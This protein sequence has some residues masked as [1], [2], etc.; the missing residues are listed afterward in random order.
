[1]GEQVDKDN[2][3][4]DDIGD[5]RWVWPWLDLENGCVLGAQ[6]LDPFEHRAVGRHL[7]TVQ[8]QPHLF[9]KAEP[10]RAR[11]RAR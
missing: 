3:S 6:P 4:N 9:M 1:V 8:S 7:V 11:A 2:G 5:N 10:A